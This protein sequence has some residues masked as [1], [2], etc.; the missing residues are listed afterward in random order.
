[1][2]APKST[3]IILL[4]LYVSC[5]KIKIKKLEE[6]ELRARACRKVKI[7]SPSCNVYREIGWRRQVLS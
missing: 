7:E 2:Y 6:Q 4:I 1:M 5:V 3:T